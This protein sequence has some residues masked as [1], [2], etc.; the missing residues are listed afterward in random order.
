MSDIINEVMNEKLDIPS[1]VSDKIGKPIKSVPKPEKPM[2]MDTKNE[3]WQTLIDAAT[4]DILDITKI[5]SF[6]QI[7][8]NREQLY[9]VL[10]AMATDPTIA[11]ALEIYAE[12]TTAENTEH[13]VV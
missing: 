12:D 8:Q 6:S 11:A 2:P 10:D 3:F 1:E 7:S 13:K 9:Q 5:D 4:N